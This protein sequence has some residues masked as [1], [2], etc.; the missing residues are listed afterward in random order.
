MGQ[1]AINQLRT[2]IGQQDIDA[3]LVSQPQNRSYLSG[4]LN[5]D[6]EGSGLLLVGAQEQILLTNHLYAEVAQKE[7]D[8][9]EVVVPESRQ[10]A[11]AVADEAKKYGWHKIGF[12]SSAMSFAE[13]EKFGNAGSGSYTLHPFEQ[14]F[15]DRLRQ[16]KQP[17]EIEL[18]KR[19]IAIT[20]ETFAHICEWI[21]PGMSEKEIQWEI[22]RFMVERGAD[23]QAFETI[24]AS[25]PNGSMPHAHASQ[26]RV[27]RG[28]MITIDMGAR[29]K[30]YCAD[31]TRTICLGEPT[32]PRIREVY[33]AVLYAM[34]ACEA[35]LHASISGF[36]ADALARNALEGVG[37]AQYYVHSTGHGV[38]LQIHEGPNL[39]QRA[40]KDVPLLAGS[41]VTV[42][43]GVYIEGWG[44]A[45]V[46][47]CV[48]LKEDGVEVLTQSPTELVVQR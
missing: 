18:L 23:E 10:Y 41:V 29:Y 14:S 7:A 4:W 47:D 40:P 24:V 1:E 11:P 16:V 21:Q 33:D 42:E 2:W 35:G 46:E 37:L 27:Q 31:M 39:S 12:E 45:R 38:G 5:D 43:P 8:G 15:I 34:K 9:W 3:F 6:I 20:D 30:G 19:A 13:Y 32:E 22:L 36:D 44:G 17:Y 28:E 26:R 25:G 48:L